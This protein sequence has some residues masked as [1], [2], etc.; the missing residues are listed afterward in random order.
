[1]KRVFA[2]LVISALLLCTACS[3]DAPKTT[4]PTAAPQATE[5]TTEPTVN[6]EDTLPDYHFSKMEYTRPDSQAVLTAQ[7]RR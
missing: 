4:D 6:A 7:D 3:G 2:L 1:M 5:P